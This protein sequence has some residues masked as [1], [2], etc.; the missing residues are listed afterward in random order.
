MAK[1]SKKE[2]ARGRARRARDNRVNMQVGIADALGL[3]T[4]A[5]SSGRFA[6]ANR[7]F[8]GPLTMGTA[9]G[10][11]GFAAKLMLPDADRVPLMAGVTSAMLGVGIVELS[12]LG[13]RHRSAAGG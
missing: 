11:G 12:L 13:A 6:I 9:I 3:A 4:G 8:M 2:L 10:L 1:A 5:Y 7:P